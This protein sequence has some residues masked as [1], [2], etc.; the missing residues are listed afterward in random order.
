MQGR[1]QL[2]LAGENVEIWAVY[3]GRWQVAT[4]NPVKAQIRADQLL[5]RPFLMQ[6]GRFEDVG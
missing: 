6:S 3:Q 1:A 5:F 2:I 4:E